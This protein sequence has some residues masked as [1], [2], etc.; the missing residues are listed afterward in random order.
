MNN[1]N[2]AAL[3]ARVKPGDLVT[4][5][6]ADG[7]QTTGRARA[8]HTG[9]YTCAPF[10]LAPEPVTADNIVSIAPAMRAGG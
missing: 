4:I 10:S 6:N 1:A 5:R 7:S 2:G 8:S 9:L 3:L